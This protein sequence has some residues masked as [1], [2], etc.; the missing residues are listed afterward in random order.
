MQINLKPRTNLK[1]PSHERDERAAAI[2]LAG[3]TVV[4]GG[5]AKSVTGGL[6]PTSAGAQ[7][8]AFKF[9]RP[10]PGLAAPADGLLVTASCVA[11]KIPERR[12][13]AALMEPAV[14]AGGC[15]YVELAVETGPR[16][17]A[18][19]GVI[20]AAALPALA[21]GARVCDTQGAHMLCLVSRTAWPGARSWAA[22]SERVRSGARVGL[23]LERGRLWVC[24]DSDG[25][26]V[27]PG[28]MS[29]GLAGRMHFS[30]ELSL[31]SGGRVQL[32][33]SARP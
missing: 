5:L 15:A 16:Q 7:A 31:K 28:P 23:L 20:E 3:S 25:Q 26:Q 27:G 1:F 18:A 32:V 21:N 14:E 29:S 30:A 11:T 6:S 13:L 33:P 8:G 24:L 2:A 9:C 17:G 10:A 19:V 12:W 22:G 4:C